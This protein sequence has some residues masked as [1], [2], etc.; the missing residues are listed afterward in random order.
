M[1]AGLLRGGVM[2]ERH[3]R[4]GAHRWTGLD[5]QV[6]VRR[7]RLL[8]TGLR[9]GCTASGEGGDGTTAGDCG[10]PVGRFKVGARHGTTTRLWRAHGARW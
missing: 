4:G 9:R 10:R 3:R 8:L 7:R 2:G 1:A 6:D 5:D